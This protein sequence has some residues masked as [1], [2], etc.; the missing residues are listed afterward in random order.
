MPKCIIISPSLYCMVLKITI[1]DDQM[2]HM[3]GN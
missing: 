3:D 2:E 1:Q